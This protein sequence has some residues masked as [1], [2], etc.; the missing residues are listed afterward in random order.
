MALT[1]SAAC[2]SATKTSAATKR[3]SFI[4]PNPTIASP[5]AATEIRTATPCRRTRGTHPEVSAATSEPIP[6]AAN[7]RPSP[8]GPTANTRSA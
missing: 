7:S 3:P 2:A 8:P 4:K 1:V 6:G 5:H